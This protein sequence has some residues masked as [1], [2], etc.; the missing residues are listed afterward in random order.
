M[1]FQTA[2]I[3][4]AE[5]VVASQDWDAQ[6]LTDRDPAVFP[7]P[8]IDSLEAVLRDLTA[9]LLTENIK[10]STP[11]HANPQATP[12]DGLNQGR[13]IPKRT[14]PEIQQIIDRKHEEAKQ[15]DLHYEQIVAKQRDRYELLATFDDIEAAG[16]PF[17]LEAKADSA[18]LHELVEALGKRYQ[19]LDKRGVLDKL[20][21]E[22]P[23]PHELD[24]WRMALEVQTVAGTDPEQAVVLLAQVAKVPGFAF[25]VGQCLRHGMRSAVWRLAIAPEAGEAERR[26]ALSDQCGA[27]TRHEPH[28]ETG[29]TGETVDPLPPTIHE[30][31]D[32]SV[33]H[34]A[35]EMWRAAKRLSD[36]LQDWR[37][38]GAFAK[39]GQRDFTQA[40]CLET[41]VS[42]TL[43]ALYRLE[44][45]IA[46]LDGKTLREATALCPHPPRGPIKAQK[47]SL[48][49]ENLG[50]VLG[51]LHPL[52]EQ[53]RELTRLLEFSPLAAMLHPASMK[54]HGP[55]GQSSGSTAHPGG[56]GSPG[57]VRSDGTASEP[58]LTERQYN[59][60]EA[61]LLLKATSPAARQTTDAIA[62]KAEGKLPNSAVKES[63]AEL[64]NQ[65]L[66]NTKPSRG[67]GVWLTD[68]GH[69]LISSVVARRT[70]Q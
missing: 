49:V 63:V 9:M 33:K 4:L 60:L 38:W 55:A 30:I 70:N 3:R 61:L 10:G 43:T 19:V 57:N 25:S 62:R 45:P 65:Q 51:T 37:A 24:A 26:A 41:S 42:D 35:Q 2:V 64:K 22:R 47:D 34:R 40:L 28:G 53:L 5:A 59:I 44:A 6:Q 29:W 14:N 31:P 56:G 23:L 27:E 8:L 13:T 16:K 32:I 68:T 12:T 48:F 7:R 21:E 17:Q 1:D 36:L 50:T 18:Y 46:F 66:V 54:L 58:V 39:R 15:Y 11:A 69:Q 67:G 52:E 20:A